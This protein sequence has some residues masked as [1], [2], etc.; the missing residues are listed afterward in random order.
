MI[1]TA[2]Y[3]ALGFLSASLLALA[4]LPLV[5]G[6]AVRL[7]RRAIEA[8]NPVSY[9]KASMARDYL[10]AQ[11]AVEQRILEVK[12]EEVGRKH[13]EEWAARNR[14][15][16]QLLKLQDQVATLTKRLEKRGLKDRLT[17]GLWSAEEAEAE[18]PAEKIEPPTGEVTEL[19]RKEAGTNAASKKALPE[20]GAEVVPLPTE[21]VPV[22]PN[23]PLERLA[24]E[25][26]REVSEM[27]AQSTPQVVD[28][29]PEEAAEQAGEAFARLKTSY[30]KLEVERNELKTKLE[31][32][33]KK[34]KAKPQS[35]RQRT[36]KAQKELKEL[37]QK[38][39]EAQNKISELSAQIK[40]VATAK[41][42]S[43]SYKTLREELKELAAQLAAAA[44][45][46]DPKLTQ[47]FDAIMQDIGTL[48]TSGAA[49][50]TEPQLAQ[51]IEKARRTGTD[52]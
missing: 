16:A 14:A 3:I 18:K 39:T 32:A 45:A 20:M 24:R 21:R 12:L 41:P 38:Y 1:E 51:R 23:H 9:A 29:S 22:S 7:T 33:E 35:A 49:E 5:W 11:H 19:P 26:S 52:S 40:G 25:I 43:D 10:R 30:E 8:S 34:L 37:Q 42:A 17:M 31:E 50:G 2:L 36:T 13:A 28:N 27:T 6:R 47:K 46:K 15:E 4:A 44:I 48:K